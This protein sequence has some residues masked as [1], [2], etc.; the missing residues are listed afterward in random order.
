MPARRTRFIVTPWYNDIP[1]SAARREGSV[2]LATVAQAV[3]VSPMTVSNAYNR[4]HKLS[5]A[6][7]ERI[8]EAARDLGY[9]G[10]NPA[11]RSLRRGRAGSIGLLFGEA[12]TYV[13]QDP[14]AVEFLRGL[15]E[16]TAKH[17]NVL[18]LIAALDADGEDGASLLANAIVDGLVVWSLPQRHPLLRLARERNIPLVTHGGPRLDGVAFVGIDDRAAAQ[19]AAEHLLQLG[20]R[21]IAVISFPF[22]PSRRARHRD[23]AQIGR[24]SYRVTRERLSGYQAAAG[25]AMS[26]SAALDVYEVAVNSRDEGHAAALELLRTSPRTTAVLAMSDELA[27]GALTAAGELGLR[28]PR[29]VSVVG[30]DDSPSARASDPA[31]TTV[32]QSLHEQGRTCARL[33]ISATRGE[34]GDGDLV[35]LAPWQLVT[36]DS[37]GRPPRR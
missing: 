10:P 18:Q 15:A 27:L 13:F 22:G 14:G 11:A 20:H 24:P 2:T 9:P 23:P 31:L 35:H 37:T 3:G 4:P 34:I 36:R 21:S 1:V 26:R 7:R 6:L 8:L 5:P 16:V 19:A 25:S 12:L 17:N 28:V 33:L 29:D 30:W 32:G